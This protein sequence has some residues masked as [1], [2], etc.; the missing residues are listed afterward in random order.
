MKT[1]PR[2]LL[3]VSILILSS[4]SITF[5]Q[6]KKAPD[7]TISSVKI[8]PYNSESGK[9]EEEYTTKSDRSFFNDLAISL[10]LT[11][12]INGEA[13]SFEV[14]RKI[15]VTVLEGKK[16]KSKT[17]EQIGLIGDGG[18]FYVP[19]WLNPAMCSDIKITAKISGQK[20]VSTKSRSVPFLCGE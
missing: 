20:T 6:G 18:K 13:G 8:V 1:V 12:E 14:G 7:Y 17:V 16:V 19:I 4:F 2:I 11:V 10:F 9:F 5:A 3:V 15:E